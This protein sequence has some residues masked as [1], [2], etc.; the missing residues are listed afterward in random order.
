[1]SYEFGKLN[2]RHKDYENAIIN[3]QK[4][5]QIQKRFIDS[6][7]SVVNR[8]YNNIALFYLFSGN[9]NKAI[10]TF[11]TLIKQSH[12][13]KYVLSAYT[14]RLTD[15]YIDRGDYYK[16]INYLK[17]AENTL[18]KTSDSALK[19]EIYKVYLAF[20][21]IYSKTGEASHYQKALSY[22]NKAEKSIVHLPSKTQLKTKIIIY[23]GYGYI[24]DEL[25]DYKKAINYYK[26]A[27][28]LGLS[29]NPIN[30]GNIATT[31]DALG[32]IN[33]KINQPH[34]AFEN[35]QKALQYD[36]LKTST[37]DNL[38]DY[39]LHSKNYEKALFNYQKAI[40][41]SIDKDDTIN[42]KKLP[43][44]SKLSQYNNKTDL[45]NDL[46]DKAN[47][48]FLYY[49]KTKNKNHLQSALNTVTLADKLVDI[50]RTES[51]EQQSKYFWRKKGVDLYM[52]ATSICYELNNPQAAF[53]FMEK[54]KSLSLLEDITAE[55]AKTN[56]DLPEKL[57]E[58]EYDLKYKI[59]ET[60][61]LLK[62]NN[63]TENQT[64]L[65]KQKNNYD[66]FL[67]SLENE[68]PGYFNYKKIIDIISLKESQL[69]M[70]TNE[71]AII[72]YILTENEGYGIWLTQNETRFFKIPE[73]QLLNQEIKTISKL[74]KAPLITK[75][76]LDSYSKITY[77]NKLFPFKNAS[78]LLL[79]K[80]LIVI[81]DYSLQYL[82]FESLVNK[83]ISGNSKLPYLIYNTEIS[84][85]YSVS[86]LHKIGQKKRTS[87][88]NFIGFAPVHFKDEKLASLNRSTSKMK[89]I[90]AL[91]SG[92]T[93]F[94][95]K[96]TKANFMMATNN[97][98]II[99]LST[100]ANAISNEEPWIA[101]HDK[102]LT[103]TELYF[104]KNQADLVVL[105]ACK[106]GL[107][108][109]VSGEGIMSLS[110][111][112]FHSGSKSV[113]SSL[114]S[115]NEKSSSEIILDFY[116]YLKEG[117]T[118]SSALRK[119]KLNYIENAQL[120]E[121]SPYFWSSLILTGS[122]EDSISSATNY[123]IYI[124]LLVLVILLTAIIFWVM[125]KRKIKKL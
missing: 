15:L 1:M 63:T 19:K 124:L 64:L 79:D 71:T 45:V 122:N 28:I 73:V 100:H 31:Y 50:I 109:L 83:P 3:T 69:K 56:A 119:A 101:F 116:T 47:A 70:T 32:Y 105:D 67:N 42:I 106:T 121:R 103:L 104:T 7:P 49:S 16:V 78:S 25:K 48:W 40:N 95:D 12:K 10:E 88:A 34:L 24:Y 114:W 6:I 38:G 92:R 22:L 55:E 23:A 94:E 60:N 5:L 102:K 53:Y 59:F 84:Y 65:Y 41:Y 9:E 44:L 117:D 57:R 87:K 89:A 90:E 98:A 99:H 97:H 82:P 108:E 74:N 43:S 58:K 66:N 2:N 26:K 77:Y 115:T 18:V 36:A 120:S 52:L 27:L 75:E 46:K 54:S 29:S 72:Q 4:A 91:F 125:R 85:V 86:L 20:Q 62:D 13:D 80:K 96:A 112:F 33:S 110:R 113:I 93:L 68:Y 51:T 123:Y 61:T 118:K 30:R 11:K 76:Q 37:Y 81:P 39:Y 21:R 14:K 17:E 35:Y 107:G 111:G 8:S